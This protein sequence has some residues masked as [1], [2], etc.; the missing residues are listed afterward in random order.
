MQLTLCKHSALAALRSLRSAGTSPAVA[1][2]QPAVSSFSTANARWHMA[3]SL[4]PGKHERSIH[5]N[6]FIC[7]NEVTEGQCEVHECWI[8]L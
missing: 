2:R 7:S 6:R 4:L 5:V 1:F 3:L 8:E